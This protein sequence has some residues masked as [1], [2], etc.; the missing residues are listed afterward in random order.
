MLRELKPL[1]PI[2][3]R[4]PGLVSRQAALESQAKAKASHSNFLSPLHNISTALGRKRG[5]CF[6]NR[7][8][9]K[10]TEIERFA[11]PLKETC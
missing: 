4:A 8:P 6:E 1:L 10:E 9:N 11:V 5:S 2:S 7:L 3:P